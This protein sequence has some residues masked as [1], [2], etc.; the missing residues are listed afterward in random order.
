MAQVVVGAPVAQSKLQNHAILPGGPGCNFVNT[1]ALGLHA[2]D[3]EVKAG[4]EQAPS[5][6]SRPAAD[7]VT[8][9]RW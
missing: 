5:Q 9:I 2:Q 4:H 8:I 7:R 6:I 3:E 1:G